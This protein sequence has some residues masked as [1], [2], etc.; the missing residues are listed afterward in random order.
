MTEERQTTLDELLDQLGIDPD[1]LPKRPEPFHLVPAD[2]GDAPMP[3]DA[4]CAW[5]VVT[6]DSPAFGVGEWGMAGPL[7]ERGDA[8]ALFEA[9]A[10]WYRGELDG[11]RPIPPTEV[12]SF[13]DDQLEWL[14]KTSRPEDGFLTWDVT[15]YRV[16][17]EPRTLIGFETAYRHDGSL[18]VNG[19]VVAEPVESEGR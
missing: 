1:E 9:M 18:S 10:A 13:G 8:E 7:K 2:Y 4:P 3:A 14:F 11:R 19:K 17:D 12:S 16:L 5:Y 15:L 6:E